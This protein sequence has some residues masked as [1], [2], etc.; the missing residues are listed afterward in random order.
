MGTGEEVWTCE[1]VEVAVGWWWC[2]KG[3]AIYLSY[4]IFPCSMER[5]RYCQ[6]GTA[7]VT[8]NGRHLHTR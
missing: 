7:V 3:A 2:G 5:S 1:R 6:Y 4:V 8:C